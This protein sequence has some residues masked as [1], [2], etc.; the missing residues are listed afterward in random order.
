MSLLKGTLGIPKTVLVALYLLDTV[1]FAQTE[2][3]EEALWQVTLLVYRRAGWCG[4]EQH[5]QEKAETSRGR[6]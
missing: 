2:T 3:N 1:F 4:C 5:L 6:L